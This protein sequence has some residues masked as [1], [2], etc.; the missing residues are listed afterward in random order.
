MVADA[1][2]PCSYPEQWDIEGLKSRVQEV[3]N[4]T[5]DFDSWMQED[6]LEPEI[7]ETRIT[8]MAEPELEAKWAQVER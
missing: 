1:C 2:P 8:E 6:A 5:P 3:L 4:L 7:I